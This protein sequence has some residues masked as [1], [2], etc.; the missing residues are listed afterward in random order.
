MIFE[1]KIKNWRSHADT[2]L[3]F[4]EGTNVLVGPNGSGKTSVLTAV[5]F[6]LFGMISDVESKKVKLE[7]LIRKN[8]QRGEVE[9]RFISPD[10]VEYSVKRTIMRGK[11]TTWAELRKADG[12]T[13]ISGSTERVTEKV[14]EI[15][16]IT[17]D[18]YERAVYSEQNRLDYILELRAGDRKR[19]IDELLGLSKFEEVRKGFGSLARELEILGEESKKK[20]ETLKKDERLQ[21][22]EEFK[23]NLEEIKQQ[24]ELKKREL[25]KI[26]QELDEIDK[27]QQRLKEIEKKISEIKTERWQIEGKIEQ[28]KN[29]LENSRKTLGE[30]AHVSEDFL[31]SKKDELES[32]FKT[33]SGFIEE[34]NK[35]KEKLIQKK[36]ELL[37]DGRSL[38]A[39]IQRLEKELVVK[40]EKRKKLEEL[41]AK[42][43]KEEIER[44]ENELKRVGGEIGRLKNL[45]MELSNAIAELGRAEST[46][47]VCDNPLPEE[48]KVSLIDKK[49]ADM[50]E[51]KRKIALLENEE[52][53]ISGKLRELRREANEEEILRRETADLELK[54]KELAEMREKLSEI[55]VE[56]PNIERELSSIEEEIQM[57]ENEKKNI[58]K[59]IN[60]ILE[61]LKTRRDMK[62]LEKL[63][64]EYVNRSKALEEQLTKLKLEFDEKKLSELEEKSR[65]L[66]QC[67]GGVQQDVKNA[68]KEI[69]RLQREI[70]EIEE[71]RKTIKEWEK[72][73][74]VRLALSGALKALQQVVMRVQTE[75]RQEFLNEVN[76]IMNSL[77]ADLYPYGD[78]TGIRL[79]SEEN[80]YVL[81]L[82]R[83]G[84]EWINVDGVASGGERTVACLALRVALAI[85]FAP[86]LKWIVFD[87]PTHNLDERS[88]QELARVMRERLPGIVR[89]IIL[90]THD[91]MFEAAVSG[92][93]YRFSRDKERDG[94]T[95]CEQVSVEHYGFPADMPARR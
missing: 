70:Q 62:E 4:Q 52:T 67:L 71:K 72:E 76:E 54:E 28:A 86:N 84:G 32:K 17:R 7:D 10:G 47:P 38:T 68:E 39:G 40:R 37:A 26:S 90:I 42:K 2:H 12:S 44:L 45:E 95:V 85:L 57:L 66:H 77:W 61:V 20:A 83:R 78:Y 11:G 63:I 56:I 64:E 33:T 50:E 80:D 14:C 27:E 65:D 73:A 24:Y 16:K 88:V 23:R 55:Q 69:D 48:R 87:E 94:P 89:Q 15:L 13:V 34:R 19:K 31:I 30:M 8:E 92:T 3:R 60:R 35:T 59:E 6:A 93:L 79:L 75:M 21:K 18:V 49:R 5:E 29:Q 46:C 82:R 58:E 53:E 1:V 41:V 36:S 43:L 74:E 25:A 51:V 91:P 81:Q 22:L 9:V